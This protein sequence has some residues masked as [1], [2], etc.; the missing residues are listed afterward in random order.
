MN[1]T[2][3]AQQQDQPQPQPQQQPAG[4]GDPVLNSPSNSQPSALNPQ[5]TPAS[6]SSIE[7]LASCIPLTDSQPPL[8]TC[9]SSLDTSSFPLS[10]GE[11][12][13]A[14]N[15]FITFYQLGHGR[16][17]PALAEKLGEP[18]Q[19]LKNW[20]S[21]FDWSDRVHFLNSGA[22]KKQIEVENE[23]R[24]KAAADWSKR[25][26]EYR[27]QEYDASQTLLNVVRCCLANFG[28]RDLEKMRLS[29]LS[30]AL[31]IASKLNRSALES[32]TTDD[33]R[34][35]LAP[36]QAELLAAMRKMPAPRPAPQPPSAQSTAPII[37]N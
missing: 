35:S 4:A 10:P 25:N 33:A 2:N 18:L 8:V 19:T 32:P 27:E 17:L 28:D 36:L 22:L 37:Q 14:Y 23:A 31:Q 20:S 24:Q 30:R 12:P 21:K 13:R 15:A 34:S 7:D 1:D 6:Q 3:E 11:T 29:E 26:A 5:P 9:H 16:S